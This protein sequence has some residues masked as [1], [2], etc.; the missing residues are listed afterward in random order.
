MPHALWLTIVILASALSMA[1][2]ISTGSKEGA[3][4]QA[5]N[6]A[7]ACQFSGAF[8]VKQRAFICER[9]EK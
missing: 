6:I 1:V 9:K 7:R 4:S 2:G 8:V 3:E 5:E